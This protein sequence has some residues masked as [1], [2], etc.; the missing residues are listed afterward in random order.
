MQPG[1]P[2]SVR[3]ELTKFSHT[4]T[5]NDR[6]GPMA[7]T[8][9]N[10]NGDLAC[11]LD[12]FD[13]SKSAPL[14]L[15]MRVIQNDSVL[16]CFQINDFILALLS[17]TPSQEQIDLAYYVRTNQPLREQSAPGQKS[18]FAVV[19]KL[20]CLAV[21]YPQSGLRVSISAS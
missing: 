9:V 7:W 1:L 12:K 3:L 20:P 13:E 8:H 10:G 15:I 4:I 6:P 18:P 21:K 11:I 14:K 19:V 2:Q 16:V 5:T 17:V